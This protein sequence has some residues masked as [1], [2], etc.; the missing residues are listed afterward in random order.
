MF[1]WVSNRDICCNVVHA[2][3]TGAS[4]IHEQSASAEVI[5]EVEEPKQCDNSFDHT[6]D[7]GSKE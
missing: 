2:D 5:D 3:G 1:R 4:T 6:E 7:T